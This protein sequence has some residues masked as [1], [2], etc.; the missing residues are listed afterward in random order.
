MGARGAGGAEKGLVGTQPSENTFSLSDSLSCQRKETKRHK[1]G[2]LHLSPWQS[3]RGKETNPPKH[4][5]N[6][7]T[8]GT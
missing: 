4:L 8:E 5:W 1:K 2:A 3:Y 7:G 6:L